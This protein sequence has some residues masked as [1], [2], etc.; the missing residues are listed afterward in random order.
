[1]STINEQISLDDFTRRWFA[2]WIE[3]DPQARSRQV[4]ELWATNGAQVLVDRPRRY[5]MRLPRWHS[6]FPS[7]GARPRRDRSS[8]DPGHAVFLAPAL[9]G[10]GWDTVAVADGTVAGS[11]YDVI[12]LDDNGRILLNHQ[13]IAPS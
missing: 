5:G 1:M 2:L 6:R 10:L 4:A 13:H 9:V 12:V 11:G 7:R 3:P 8:G